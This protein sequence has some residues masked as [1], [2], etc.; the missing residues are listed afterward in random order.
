MQKEERRLP[1]Y[2]FTNEEKN[3]FLFRTSNRILYEVSF[4]PSGYIFANDPELQPFVFEISIVVIENPTDK[5]PPA[6]PRVP[7]TIAQIFGSFFEQHERVVVYV[8]DTSDQRG[9]VRQRKFL[10]WFGYYK[11]V[12]YAQFNDTLTDEE[13]VHYYV[14][15]IIRLDNPY[16]RR[17]LLA[18]DDLLTDYRK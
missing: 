7:P 12:D 18:F 10:N 15:L 16:R 3:S 2:E 6:D 17:L 5:H 13:G 4:K 11:G 9:S 14:S 8:C 1:G